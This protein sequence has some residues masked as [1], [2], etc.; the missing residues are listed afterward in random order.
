MPDEQP[1]SLSL[2]YDGQPVD[3]RRALIVLH[4]LQERLEHNPPSFQVLLAL[5]R[6]ELKGLRPDRR[7]PNIARRQFDKATPAELLVGLMA[8]GFVRKD[9]SVEPLT[10]RVLLAGFRTVPDGQLVGNPFLLQ[11]AKDKETLE[12]VQQEIEGKEKYL[13]RQ[14]MLQQNAHQSR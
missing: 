6:G 7:L 13:F 1:V 4:G 8:V 9:G 12:T 10:Q 3:V 2:K 5:A 14:W 11:D